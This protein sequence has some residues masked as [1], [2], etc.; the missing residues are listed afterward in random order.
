MVWS[1]NSG[2]V[3][4]IALV[5]GIAALLILLILLI[6]PRRKIR[7][8]EKLMRVSE[9]V[10]YAIALTIFLVIILAWVLTWLQ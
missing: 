8:E 6:K 5:I 3:C 2:E 7:N 9:W 4:G 1:L 10:Y